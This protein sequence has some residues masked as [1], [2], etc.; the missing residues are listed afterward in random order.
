MV[1]ALNNSEVEGRRIK[2]DIAKAKAAKA[3]VVV[4]TG[5]EAAT[6]MAAENRLE[7]CKPSVKKKKAARSASDALVKEG[8]KAAPTCLEPW[9]NRPSHAGWSW[10]VTRRASGR[11]P[12]YV[13]A[14]V[15]YV[16]GVL[17]SAG[18]ITNT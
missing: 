16:C 8:L 5:A 13:P 6:V 4:E 11:V 7:N 2:V 1:K 14:H 12:P 17:E 9:L 15:R 3:V 18:W 10:T